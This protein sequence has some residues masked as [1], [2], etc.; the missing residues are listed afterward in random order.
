VDIWL[1]RLRNRAECVQDH[2]HDIC[3]VASL[4]AIDRLIAAM[5]APYLSGQ[6]YLQSD[7]G[8]PAGAVVGDNDRF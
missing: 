6:I 5:L 1:T 8:H 3:C 2:R 4:A 7:F